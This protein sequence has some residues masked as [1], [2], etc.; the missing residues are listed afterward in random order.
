MRKVFLL[1]SL[2]GLT[3]PLVA[4]AQPPPPPPPPPGGGGGYSG[5]PTMNE[6][7]MRFDVGL[8]AGLP[9]E[10]LDEAD[11]SPGINLQ[12]GYNFMPNI[13]ILIGVR[14]FSIQAEGLDEQGVDLSNYDFDI[15]ARYAF[16]ISPTAKAFIEGM[17]IYSTVA[18][19]AM[20]MSDSESDIGF[21]GRGGVM[22]NVSGKISVGGAVSYTTAE[23]NDASAAWLGLEGFV[24]FGF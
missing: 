1:G 17:L 7:K 16:P 11:T 19:D 20:G 15:G 22:F 5:D 21:G 13:G 6:P 8:I 18:I 14:Y 12:F 10:D 4:A 9:Q 23:I 3:L 24:S 2:V